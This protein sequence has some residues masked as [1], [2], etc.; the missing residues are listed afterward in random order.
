MNNPRTRLKR[1]SREAVEA[2]GDDEDKVLQSVMDQ[3]LADDH[4]VSFIIRNMVQKEVTS[5]IRDLTTGPV[6]DPRE[7]MA[8]TPSP[9]LPAIRDAKDQIILDMSRMKKRELIPLAEQL[10]KESDT[11]AEAAAFVRAVEEQ[12][13]EGE[14]VGERFTKED[15]LKIRGRVSIIPERRYFLGQKNIPIRNGRSIG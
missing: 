7:V 3:V 2:Y 9:I 14:T 11:A 10:E 1:L 15:L 12:L 5:T 4:F 13:A 6:T 8:R